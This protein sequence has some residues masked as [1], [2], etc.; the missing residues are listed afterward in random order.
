MITGADLST[1]PAFASVSRRRSSR[2]RPRA[3]WKIGC[4]SCWVPGW[5]V[6]VARSEGIWCDSWSASSQPARARSFCHHGC[7][8]P[9]QP[10][11]AAGRRQVR[12]LRAPTPLAG[13]RALPRLRQRCGD[14]RR[15]RRHAAVPATLSVQGLRRALRRPHRHGAGRTPSAA[16]GVGVVPLLHGAE[17]LQPADCPGAAAEPVRRSG[18]DRA[19]APRL[20]RQ[21]PGGAARRRGGDRRG[22][23]RGRAQGPARGRG[24]K[25]R[26]G[27]RRRLAGAPGRGT[28]E[29]DKPPILGLIQQGGQVVLHMLANVQQTTIKPII[30]ATVAKGALIDTDEYGVYARLLAWGYQHKTVCHAQG[31]Y[32]RDEDGDGFCEVHVNTIEGFWSLLRSWL[33]PHRGISQEKLPLYLGFFQFVHNA[34][35][36][37]RALLGA[38]IAAL[39]A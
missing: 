20:G 14:P 29:K 24:Q 1:Q 22:L 34:R 33:R 26:L 4:G 2:A 27:R 17:P 11:G 36:R 39:V 7:T 3:A 15:V 19:A 18:H 35:R 21:D 9:G 12:R 5:W 37:G 31:E 25:G 16:A 28:L 10:L 23:R 30:E 32:A 6:W 8:G 38:L 13:G